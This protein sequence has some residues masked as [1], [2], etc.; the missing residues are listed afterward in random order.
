[1]LLDWT[2]KRVLKFIL[3]RTLGR[4]LKTEVDLDQIDVQL[5]KGTL[6]LQNVLLN[7]DNINQ[8]L[9]RQPLRDSSICSRSLDACPSMLGCG[10]VDVCAATGGHDQQAKASPHDVLQLGGF[11]HSISCLLH[12]VQCHPLSAL[13]RP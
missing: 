10:S 8:Q 7:C 12:S 13:C 9:V 5:G 4:Y 6:E 11:V 1:M 3:K 2:L